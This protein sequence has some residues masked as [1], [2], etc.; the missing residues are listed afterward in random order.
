MQFATLIVLLTAFLI[1]LSFSV[2]NAGEEEKG[3]GKE[4][5]KN[6]EEKEGSKG[7]EEDQKEGKDDE[8]EKSGALSLFNS[9]S[10]IKTAS[11]AIACLFISI[12]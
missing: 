10:L 8:K 4:E 11:I 7:E 9:N 12:H 5:E 1:A 3:K 2:A 6:K